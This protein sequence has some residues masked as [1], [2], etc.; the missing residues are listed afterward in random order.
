[1][2]LGTQ[3]KTKYTANLLCFFRYDNDD[4]EQKY[5]WNK[6][7]TDISIYVKYLIHIPSSTEKDAS[8]FDWL[9]TSR[10]LAY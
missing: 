4:E 1:M 9:T 10:G 7:I 3:R 2:S 8:H 5:T 6:L